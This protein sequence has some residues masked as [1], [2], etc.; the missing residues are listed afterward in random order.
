[1]AALH[2]APLETLFLPLAGGMLRWP[3]RPGAVPEG[4]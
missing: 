3:D 1:M 2:D 4:A